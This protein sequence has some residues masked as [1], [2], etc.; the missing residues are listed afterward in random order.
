MPG[1]HEFCSPGG[2]GA[3]AVPN[4][5]STGVWL[6]D[7]ATGDRG[8]NNKPSPLLLALPLLRAQGSAV[9]N[10]SAHAGGRVASTGAGRWPP[11][12]QPDAAMLPWLV[13]NAAV[14][15]GA[16]PLLVPGRCGLCGIVADGGVGA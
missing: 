11:H 2:Y 6:T 1:Q 3:V 7:V 9:M 15:T 14:G 12:V 5:G 8:P 10:G 4:T 16:E 13:A